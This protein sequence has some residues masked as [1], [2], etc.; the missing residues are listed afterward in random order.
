MRELVFVLIGIVITVGFFIFKNNARQK[1]YRQTLG[2]VNNARNISQIFRLVSL[3]KEINVRVDVWTECQDINPV[4]YITAISISTGLNEDFFGLTVVKNGLPESLIKTAI[5]EISLKLEMQVVKEITP[6]VY[7]MITMPTVTEPDRVFNTW[8]I[9]TGYE[10]NDT[11]S[12]GD[13]KNPILK[14]YFCITDDGFLKLFK[15]TCSDAA[16]EGAK[17]IIESIAQEN[18]IVFTPSPWNCY[19]FA[20]S[21]YDVWPF[22]QLAAP[23]AVAN[24]TFQLTDK[25]EAIN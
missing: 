4:C 9:A 22:F 20:G 13:E 23:T 7:K 10:I 15:M 21:P 25:A 5:N 1:R 3:T 16:I 12:W 6:I 18:S 11:L 19:I 24:T 8:K 14:T 2:V 17:K